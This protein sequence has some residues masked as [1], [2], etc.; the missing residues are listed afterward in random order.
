MLQIEMEKHKLKKNALKKELAE[1]LLRHYDDEHSV[2]P[3]ILDFS[4]MPD[5]EAASLL[6]LSEL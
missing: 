1:L 6:F 4:S 2:D 3:E 5:F